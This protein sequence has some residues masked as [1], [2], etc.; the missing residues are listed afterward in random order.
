MRHQ[1]GTDARVERTSAARL[2][3]DSRAARGIRPDDPHRGLA[4][5][6]VTADVYSRLRELI[7][8]GG[9]APGAPLIESD[10][11]V[12]LAVSR[13]PIR[14]T[15]LRLQQ[16]GYIVGTPVGRVTRAIVAPLTGEDMRELHFIFGAFEGLAVRQVTQFPP[17]IRLRVA[18]RMAA[19]NRDLRDACAGPQRQVR[20][21]Q[22]LHVRFHRCCAEVC[23]GRRLPGHLN[24]LQPQIERYERFYTGVLVLGNGFDASLLEHD[25]IIEAVRQGDP[26]R[27]ERAVVVNWRNGAERCMP[28]VAMFG[29]RGSW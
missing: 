20:Y 25:E 1:R 12:R 27:A 3:Q 26:E 23:E 29:E 13:T 22:D 16:E 5:G 11:S 6:G 24:A 14:A 9:L 18:D 19:V 28:I 7:V 8:S 15:L 21:A 17:D 10:L 2:R 4:A